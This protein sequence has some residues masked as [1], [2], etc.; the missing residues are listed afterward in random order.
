MRWL[1]VI[2]FAISTAVLTAV[3]LCVPVF[4]NTSFYRIGEYYEAWIFFAVIIMSNCKKPLES[5]L[6]TFVFFLINQPLLYLFRAFGSQVPFSSMGWGLFGYYRVWFIITLLTFPAAFVG[7]Y[8]TKRNWLS[9]LIFS[10]VIVFL[11]IIAC[12]TVKETIHH[13]PYML[14]ASLFCIFQIVIYLLVFFQKTSQ[15]LVGISLTIIT[16][17][18]I[19]LS[20]SNV[21]LTVDDS[22]PDFPKLS[23]ETT[24]TVENPEIA[25]VE[26]QDPQTAAVHIRLTIKI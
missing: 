17:I 11:S 15:R 22:L 24:V 5:A 10:P 23:S 21:D 20:S 19:L 16:V 25:E 13:F 6:K 1:T 12:G 8:I 7:W 14:L 3:F 18:I 4:K 2:L 26:L 9:I